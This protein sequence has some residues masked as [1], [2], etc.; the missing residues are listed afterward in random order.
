MSYRRAAIV[1][2]QFDSRL[3]GSGAQWFNDAAFALAVKRAGWRLVYDPEIRVDHYLAPR[4]RGDDRRATT[5]AGVYDH[6]YNETLSLLEHLGPAHRAVFMTFGLAIGT[7][8]APGLAQW[9]RAG[10]RRRP[11]ALG[12]HPG[13][14]AGP[15]GRM[16][17][18]PMDPAPGLD[19]SPPSRRGLVEGGANVRTMQL[20]KGW[21]PDESGGLNRYY[22]DLVTRLPDVG[23]EVVGFVAGGPSVSEASSGAIRAFAPR[24]ANLLGRLVRARSEVGRLLAREPERL[25]V[26]HFALYAAPCLDLLRSGRPFVVHFHGPWA[27][28]SRAEGAGALSAR[29][30]AA[31]EAAVYRRATRCI[32]LSR[33]FGTLLQRTYGVPADR[34]RVIPGGIDA[35]RFDPPETRSAARR[36]LGWPADRPIVLTVRRLV[37]RMGLEDLLDAARIARREVAGLVVVIAGTG[38]LAGE[39]EARIAAQGLADTVRLAG[40]VPDEDLPLAYRAAD[41]SVVPSLTLEGFGLVAA[42]SLAAGT[43]VLATPVGGL[44]EVLD[45]LG[46]SCLLPD[47]GPRPLARAMIDA[48]RGRISLPGAPACALHAR[49]RFDWPVVTRRIKSVYEEAAA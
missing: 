41:L 39:L 40:F 12:L 30:K 32:V 26:A 27:A 17:R 29:L 21:F 36:R 19:P 43:P 23:V 1:D 48:L 37:R 18:R 33:A 24:D 47:A 7:R 11:G 42:E 34:V 38:S 10:W 9:L 49:E 45:G 14:L 31:L 8:S 13:R 5:A 46:E 20:G 6:V 2:R 16:A 22:R 28:E 25:V 3:R 4:D 35:D 15:P 44:P